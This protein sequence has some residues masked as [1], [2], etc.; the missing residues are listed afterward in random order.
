MGK[1]V[2]LIALVAAACGGGNEDQMGLDGPQGA[3]GPAGRDGSDGQ[4]GSVGAPGHRGVTGP[5]GPQGNDGPPGRD[6]SDGQDGAAATPKLPTGTR[7]LIPLSTHK[8]GIFDQSAAEIVK[9]H[10]GTHH[11][12]VVNAAS[13]RV[14]VLQLDAAGTLHEKNELDIGADIGGGF[15]AGAAN[16]VDVHG[17]LLAVAIDARPVNQPGRVAFY[18]AGTLQYLG[19]AVVGA[20]PDMVTFTP[21]GTKLLVANEGEQV[22]DASERII[23]DPEGSVSIV[24][25]SGA[26]TNP[27]VT[28]VSFASWNGRIE[29]LRA[30]GVRIPRLDDGFYAPDAADKTLTVAKDLEPEYIAVSP[31]SK[32]AFVVLQEN[33]AF[34]VIDV[35]TATVRDIL[36]LGLKDFSRGLPR[37][38]NYTLPKSELPELGATPGGQILHLG[39]FS[40]LWYEA[41]ESTNSRKVFYVVPD[42]GPNASPSEINE[43]HAGKERPH[44]IPDYTASIYQL[45]LENGQ[46]SLGTEIPLFRKD[47][48]TPIT[49]KPNHPDL[50]PAEFP[51]DT[52]G[53]A[54]AFDALGGDME[55]IVIDP[56]D[57]SFWLVDEYRPAIYNFAENGIL[58]ERFVPEGTAAIAGEAMGTFG[59][60]TLPVEYSARVPNRGFEAVALDPDRRVLYAF[61]QSPLANPDNATANSSAV[62]RVLGIDADKASATFGRPVEEFLYLLEAS[63]HRSSKVDK[64]GDAVYAG[65]GRFYVIE[66][67]SSFDSTGKKFIYRMDLKG[68]TNV[69]GMSVGQ[70]LESMSPDA[71]WGAGIRPVNKV[72]VLNLPSI[73]YTAGDKAEGLALLEDGSLA[74]LNDNDFGLAADEIPGDGTVALATANTDIVLGH[75]TFDGPNGLDASDQDG[76]ISIARWPVFGIYMPDGVTSFASG[77]QTFYITAN[78]GDSREY[79]VARLRSLGNAGFDPVV[80]PN[81]TELRENVTGIGRLNVSVLD[82]DLDG[83]GAVE[84]IHTLGGRSL[85]IWDQYGNLVYDSGSLIEQVT[86]LAHPAHF[87]SNHRELSFDTRSDDKGPEPE[88]VVVGE[89]GGRL[90]AFL[91]LERIGGIFIMDVTNPHSPQFVDYVNHREFSGVGSPEYGLGGDLGAEGLCFIPAD[92]SPTGRPMLLVANEVSG[93]TTAFH[94]NL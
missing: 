70:S 93:T 14:T 13:G 18:N 43:N 3:V 27:P 9:H 31:D 38:T 58:I 94:V 90:F 6:G 60:E 82:G 54:L 28:T 92:Q 48:T 80:F 24:D 77:G 30:R 26:V 67:D 73:G 46:L 1:F 50:D 7:A 41:S 68:A 35:A 4:D 8:M 42:R 88:D 25:V 53:N 69:L 86:A 57:G 51:V 16:S 49:G 66:R 56:M 59:E 39:G 19:S 76:A 85:S 34:A 17:D 74:V 20:L 22:R 36:P 63:S 62:I 91:G 10:A 23:E 71:L 44:V 78:E 33:N 12:F 61:I 32:T 52:Q 89:V 45:I 11:V 84:Q 79:D 37:A 21:D 87:N 15:T 83:D 75:I 64:I 47:G 5:K 29:E 2:A 72:K 55:G 40:G 81:R 65:G